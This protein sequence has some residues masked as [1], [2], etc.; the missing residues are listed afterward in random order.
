M[1]QSCPGTK[2]RPN[3]GTCDASRESVDI[4]SLYSAYMHLAILEEEEKKNKKHHPS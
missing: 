4:C 1:Q 2:G 3:F